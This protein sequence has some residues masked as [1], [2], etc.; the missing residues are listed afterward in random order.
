MTLATR[1]DPGARTKLGAKGQIAKQQLAEVL[2]ARS[3]GPKGRLGGARKGQMDE[4]SYRLTM[5]H[6]DGQQECN[7]SI[8]SN[9]WPD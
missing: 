2:L 8:E 3:D 5:E 7:E 6:E 1:E 9:G 4:E